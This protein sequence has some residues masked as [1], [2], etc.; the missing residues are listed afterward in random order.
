M[1]M[2]YETVSPDGHRLRLDRIGVLSIVVTDGEDTA[3][4]ALSPQQSAQLSQ[5]LVGDLREQVRRL[6]QAV[7]DLRN[8]ALQLELR[9]ALRRHLSG[10]PTAPLTG[11]AL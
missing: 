2:L 6:L 4:I 5:A 10:A 3:A 1:T 7:D 11:A 8:P 9:E